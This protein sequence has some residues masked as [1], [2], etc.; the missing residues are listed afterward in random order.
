M[1]G[2]GGGGGCK[3]THLFSYTW[4]AEY[5]VRCQFYILQGLRGRK[6]LNS[7][8]IEKMQP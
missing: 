6:W 4:D 3:E 8:Q 2:G 1:D 5:L 7:F